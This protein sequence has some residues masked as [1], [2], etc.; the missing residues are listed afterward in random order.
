MSDGGVV[1]SDG[2]IE[3]HSNAIEAARD[4]LDDG[5]EP[6]RGTGGA[7]G[8]AWPFIE[9]VGGAEVSQRDSTRVDG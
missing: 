3:V 1:R 9:S 8:H 5:D 4:E 2:V 6:G 7:L